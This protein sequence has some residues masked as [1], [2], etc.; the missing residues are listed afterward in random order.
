MLLSDAGLRDAH[1]GVDGGRRIHLLGH[2]LRARQ[3]E[4]AQIEHFLQIKEQPLHLPPQ[5]VACQRL[6]GREARRV[7]DEVNRST[8]SRRVV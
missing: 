3:I 5:S 4:V 8:V 7:Q 1:G 2:A 6:F